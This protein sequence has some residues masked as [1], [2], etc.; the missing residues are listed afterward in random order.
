MEPRAPCPGFSWRCR[1]WAQQLRRAASVS[2]CA[3]DGG[4]ARARGIALAWPPTSARKAEFRA[5]GRYLKTAL[6]KASA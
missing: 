2:R 5:L 1:K 6:D 4:K 3:G